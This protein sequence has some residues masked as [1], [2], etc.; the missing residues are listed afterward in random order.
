MDFRAHGP[1]GHQCK[2]VQL[3]GQMG[4]CSMLLH[5]NMAKDLIPNIG[6]VTVNMPNMAVVFCYRKYGSIHC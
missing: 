2:G 6:Q 3:L 5:V 4:Q 1:R